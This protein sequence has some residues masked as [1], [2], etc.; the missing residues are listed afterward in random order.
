MKDKTNKYTG[1]YKVTKHSSHHKPFRMQFNR[2]GV[3]TSK[4][5]ETAREAAIAY[6]MMLIK[7]NMK[8]VNIL[9][10]A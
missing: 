10:K 2:E 8:P 7:F 6:D 3:Q 4:C 1:V 5:Y 9:R